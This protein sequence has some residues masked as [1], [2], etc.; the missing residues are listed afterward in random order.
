[1]KTSSTIISNTTESGKHTM[2][3]NKVII[4]HTVVATR[5]YNCPERI[6][7]NTTARVTTETMSKLNLTWIN[8]QKEGFQ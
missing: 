8:F 1:M 3:A 4:E 6:I 2:S 5:Y 7:K